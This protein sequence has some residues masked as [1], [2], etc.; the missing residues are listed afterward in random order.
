LNTPFSTEQFLAVFSEYN[1]AI[2]PV[3]IGA[4]IAGLFAVAALW[5]KSLHAARVILLVLALMWVWNGVGYHFLFFSAINPA[6]KLFAALFVLQGIA[7]ATCAIGTQRV[8]FLISHDFSSRAGLSV[9]GFAMLI[10]PI[11]GWLAGH[12]F[13]AGPMFG[14]A[15]CPTTL[16]TF[17]MLLLARGSAVVWLSI[18]PLLWSVIGLAAALQLGIIEDLALPVAGIVLSCTLIV[19]SVR[20]RRS[21]G[22]DTTALQ[23]S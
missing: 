20:R 16:Y 17:G 7:L 23:S 22:S 12:G 11:L 2:W 3:Q 6:A 21:H 8:S 5:L 19:Q 13:T 4:F 10:Y 1:A 15:P 14:V 18:I 9:I